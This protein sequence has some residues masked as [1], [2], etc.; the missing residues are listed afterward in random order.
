MAEDLK[1]YAVPLNGL[2]P[3]RTT[4]VCVVAEPHLLHGE[5]GTLA[6]SCDALVFL[7]ANQVPK[8]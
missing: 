2:E 1:Q 8:N 6:K 4:A 7:E 3:F 5:P